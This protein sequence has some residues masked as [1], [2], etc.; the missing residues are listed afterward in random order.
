VSVGVVSVDAKRA[1]DLARQVRVY[2][3]GVSVVY[4]EV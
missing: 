1:Y 3:V 2:S 4:V